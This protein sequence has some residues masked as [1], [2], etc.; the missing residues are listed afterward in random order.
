MADFE[1]IIR[2]HL[3]ANIA[4]SNTTSK[5]QAA[6]ANTVAVFNQSVAS[7]A[8]TQSVTSSWSYSYKKYMTAKQKEIKQ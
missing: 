5:C 8:L 6:P 4:P 2:P 3:P 7:T 1:K